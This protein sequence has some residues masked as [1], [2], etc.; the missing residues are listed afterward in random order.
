MYQNG[1]GVDRT[2]LGVVLVQNRPRLEMLAE[3]NLGW[4]YQNGAGVDKDYA[5]ALSWFRSRPRREM[6]WLRTISG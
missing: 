5:Q 4:M 2:I 6:S 1:V 3:N